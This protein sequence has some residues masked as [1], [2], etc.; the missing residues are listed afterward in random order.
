[1]C[2]GAIVVGKIKS[3]EE[4]KKKQKKNLSEKFDTCSIWKVRLF[5]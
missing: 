5:P 2:Y 1:M 4:A 3:D